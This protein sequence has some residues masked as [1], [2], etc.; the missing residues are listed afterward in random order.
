[1][2]TRNEIP[3]VEAML[4]IGI[5]PNSI[6]KEHFNSPI[7][8][9]SYPKKF[10]SSPYNNSIFNVHA[11]YSSAFLKA[12][13]Y[14]TNEAVSSAETWSSTSSS[15]PAIQLKNMSLRL[16]Y[17]YYA[18]QEREC[19]ITHEAENGI[20]RLIPYAFCIVSSVAIYECHKCILFKF[21]D[22][23]MQLLKGKNTEQYSLEFYMSLLCCT[24]NFN[25][26][27][28]GGIKIMLDKQPFI[29]YCHPSPRPLTE[30][31]VSF[32]LLFKCVPAKQIMELINLLLLERKIILVWENYGQ[33]GLIIEPL[34]L[35]LAPLYK[36]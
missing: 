33:L 22:I 6:H 10:D 3:F 24:L 9:E 15:H 32:E 25:T 4:A 31:N 35:L 20:S 21:C 30:T 2:S 23:F 11:S 16:P 27:E 28:T 19:T 36:P 8:L 26:H 17:M 1:M 7:I 13:A 29:E 34:L 14:S 12:T 5:P 18:Q